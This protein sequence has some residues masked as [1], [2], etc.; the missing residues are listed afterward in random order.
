MGTPTPTP[1]F[2]LELSSEEAIWCTGGKTAEVDSSVV[3]F[4]RDAVAELKDGVVGSVGDVIAM[5]EDVPVVLIV[6]ADVDV[7]LVSDDQV[8]GRPLSEFGT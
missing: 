8:S 4:C 1:A 2:I 6:D 7:E 5:A 3:N